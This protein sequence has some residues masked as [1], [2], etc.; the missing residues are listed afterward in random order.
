MSL[1][2]NV[3]HNNYIP[4]YN[5]SVLKKFGFQNGKVIINQT[6]GISDLKISDKDHDLIT[7]DPFWD[8][9]IL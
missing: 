2:S 8:L 9:P 1:I 7:V 4:I 5:S 3:M 6:I